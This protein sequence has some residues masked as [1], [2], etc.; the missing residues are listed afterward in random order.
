MDRR[1]FLLLSTIAGLPQQ[2]LTCV[3]ALCAAA[4][5][6]RM[7][8]LGISSCAILCGRNIICCPRQAS[9][10]IRARHAIFAESTTS[11]FMGASAE[12]AGNMPSAPT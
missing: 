11:S 9:S 12:G 5:V 4:L 8:R 1:N 2:R 6:H 7:W 10:A 3:R